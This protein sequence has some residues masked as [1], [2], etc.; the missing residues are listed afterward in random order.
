MAKVSELG[1]PK[2]GPYLDQTHVSLT[3]KGMIL[4]VL[5]GTPLIDPYISRKKV[6]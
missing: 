2:T 4:K 3:V 5:C 1:L 6:N